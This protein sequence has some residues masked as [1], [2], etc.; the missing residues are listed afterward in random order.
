[1]VNTF[2]IRVIPNQSTASLL[3]LTSSTAIKK[4]PPPSGAREPIVGPEKGPE[5]PFP[6]KV[7]GPVIKG[8]GR[9]SKE[10][11]MLWFCLK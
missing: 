5:S 11:R 4:M 8:F 9:G 2:I 10:V 6:V 7:S 1:V 3:G